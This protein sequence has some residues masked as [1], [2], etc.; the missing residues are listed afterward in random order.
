VVTSGAGG[1]AHPSAKSSAVAGR[2]DTRPVV[3][4]RHG[5][6]AVGHRRT[7]PSALRPAMAGASSGRRDGGIAGVARAPD[8][9]TAS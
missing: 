4:L 9:P 7:A 6:F 5:S 1:R 8:I 2:K 3:M